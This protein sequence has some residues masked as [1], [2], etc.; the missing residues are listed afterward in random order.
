ME[1]KELTVQEKTDLRLREHWTGLIATLTDAEKCRELERTL[2][3]KKV[4]ES[5]LPL[6]ELKR[7]IGAKGIAQAIDIQLTKLV[8]S[9]NVKWNLN[10]HQIKTI[11]EDLMDKFPNETIEDFILVFKKARQNEYGEVFR[12]DSAVVFG[13]VEKYLDEKYQVIEGLLMKEKDK[14]YEKPPKPKKL[15]PDDPDYEDPN[16]PEFHWH[17][18]WLENLRRETAPI[19]N[20]PKMSDDEITRLGKEKPPL[21]RALTS[22]WAEYEVRCIKVHAE[23]QAHAERIVETAIRH[24]LLEEDI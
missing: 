10:E 15:D 8:A 14:M 2:T 4:V 7:V 21:K 17:D 24:G 5:A 11:I 3:V 20:I 13:W 6:A 16:A 22:G 23:D 12:L 19:S 1:S 9:L 18:A